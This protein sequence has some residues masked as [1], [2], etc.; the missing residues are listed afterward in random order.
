MKYHSLGDALL[1]GTK[2]KIRHSSVLHMDVLV[3]LPKEK[4]G[5]KGSPHFLRNASRVKNFR[6]ACSLVGLIHRLAGCQLGLQLLESR[7]FLRSTRREARTQE[8]TNQSFARYRT[9]Q[10]H[11]APSV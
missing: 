11:G 5:L 9:V 6:K 3:V 8:D 4:L 10:S 7:S 2:I 1:C